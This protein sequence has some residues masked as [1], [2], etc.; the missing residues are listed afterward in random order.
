MNQV[1][2]SILQWNINGYFSHLEMLQIL[3]KEEG[4]TVIGLQ[5]THF[6]ERKIHCPRNFN[7]FHKIRVDQDR[8]SGGVSI[9][10]RNNIDAHEI[11]INTNLEAVA[12]SIELP[13]K[14]V[15]IC[16]IYIPPSTDF[17]TEDISNLLRQIPSPRVVIGDFNS[18]NVIW[19]SL[20]TDLKGRHLFDAID[21]VGLA[22]LNNGEKTR[23]NSSSGQ[24]TALD[25]SL[26]EP[27]LTLT[28]QWQVLPFL[29]G[30]DHFPI[31]ITD[32]SEIF[33]IARPE[34]WNL[35]KADWLKY[36]TII[37]NKINA[38][39]KN[40][41]IDLLVNSFTDI[42]TQTGEESIGKISN[43]SKRNLVP[44]W[45]DQ[46]KISI[47]L[48]KQ[49]LNKYKKE[50]TTENMLNYKKLRAKARFIVKKSKKDSWTEYVSTLGD[51]AS[52]AEVWNKIKKISGKN[53]YTP[54]QS[55]LKDGTTHTNSYDIAN[56]FANTY[57]NYSSNQNFTQEF[58]S[59][60]QRIE[61]VPIN[62]ADENDSPLNI[63]ITKQELEDALSII[64]NSSPGPDSI[65]AI[66]LKNL[67]ETGKDFL[68]HIY[69]HIWTKQKF[70][71]LWTKA[72]II[73]LPKPGKNLKTA[74]SFRPISLTCVMCKTLEKIINKRLSWYLERKNM[75]TPEQSGFRKQRSTHDNIIELESEVHEAFIND[76]KCIAIFFDIKR[77]YDTAWR[78]RIVQQLSLWGINGNMIGFIKN[79][80]LNRSFQVR[81]NNTTSE[82]I[83]QENGIPQG[84]V[85]SVTLF[86][87]AINNI[88][89]FISAPVKCRLF[90]DDLVI[91]IKGKNIGSMTNI[92]QQNLN[93]LQEW[94]QTTGFTFSTEKTKCI[95]F[96]K[97]TT[98]VSPLIKI[99]GRTLQF[100]D[101]VK[102]LGMTFD[103]R[104]T[105]KPHIQDLVLKCRKGLNI[106]KVLS[107]RCW[108]TDTNVLL[109]V[110]RSLIRSKIDY[111]SIAY[112]SATSSVLKLLDPI[113]NSAIRLALGAFYTSPVNSLLCQASEPPLRL[114]RAYLSLSYATSVAAN[115]TNPTNYYVFSNRYKDLFN[116]RARSRPTFYERIN[117]YNNKF[118]I[119][120]PKF[121][122]HDHLMPP[123][124]TI[125]KAHCLTDLT[126]Y[127]KHETSPNL[128]K[129]EL[130]SLLN[131]LPK[132]E[133]IYT[134]ASR[135][136]EGTGAAV[137]TANCTY[138]F[139]MSEY[140]TTYTAELYAVLQALMHIQQSDCRFSAV[141]TDSLSTINAL[142]N[143]TSQHPLIQ[144][145][146]R[147][148][149]TIQVAGKE[150]A[151]IWVPSHIGIDGNELA[152]RAAREAIGDPNSILVPNTLPADFKC[153]VRNQI[154]N[155]WQT[156]WDNATDKLRECKNSVKL[157]ECNLPKRKNQ[158]LVNRLR[159]GHTKLTHSYLILKENPPICEMC[160]VTL[161]VKHI[162][163]DCP[164]YTQKRLKY[165]LR[166][167]LQE[168]LNKDLSQTINYL[169]DCELINEI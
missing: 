112:D 151:F 48:Y 76:Q 14:N 136:N 16:N 24:S 102:F 30:S 152:D 167:N 36:Q 111:G 140:T 10:V 40:N 87:A 154:I 103:N 23:F 169:K 165:N 37:E 51:S 118:Q 42:L 68:L 109:K 4:P 125:T 50:K 106:L 149:H 45:N 141:I 94:S 129:K 156:E 115:Q 1:N 135:T 83:V 88:T 101:T 131:K 161:T 159:I 91:L 95:F 79:F 90:A 139:K 92:L 116:N 84:S 158:V 38:L 56:V 113:H 81:V 107:N 120:F 127:S 27:A 17:S 3:I 18:H 72:I 26:C 110:Y 97:K 21:M 146:Y 7:G 155:S 100:H 9:F 20:N 57:E 6:K 28:L 73:P 114:R 33:D 8:A 147:V 15:S 70:P 2:H 164:R 44:W 82:N 69:N 19:G 58:S 132:G 32:S 133:R 78:H 108:G 93:K 34:K 63:L 130:F 22:I 86:L 99:Y 96:S 162:L 59:Y 64:K 142:N 157:W 60:K 119:A 128:I 77:A 126:K 61:K 148:L 49:A 138:K 123:P 5:E 67:P 43:Y 89:K 163:I 29:Y 80:L 124:W 150:V 13:N 66:F 168:I 52:S 46:C 12:V 55:I 104:L 53:T 85:L 65:P 98:N 35:K 75:I 71:K 143:V 145:V 144:R 11:P 39:Q 54:I 122:Q 137:V 74:E 62:I 105:W 25:L 117:R 166:D 153:F 134:D 47:K 160:S 31:L 41:E 121:F